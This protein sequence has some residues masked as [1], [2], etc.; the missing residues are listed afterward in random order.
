MNGPKASFGRYMIYFPEWKAVMCCPT[1]KLSCRHSSQAA[2][3]PQTKPTEAPQVAEVFLLPLLD[4]PFTEPRDK[5][6]FPYGSVSNGLGNV[7]ANERYEDHE[8][9]TYDVIDP[10]VST[11]R[12][13]S[14]HMQH[15]RRSVSSAGLML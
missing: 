7:T 1:L 10:Q 4:S 14:L 13:I 15:R 11:S 9:L 8:S 6:A 12:N 2:D 5:M 3:T